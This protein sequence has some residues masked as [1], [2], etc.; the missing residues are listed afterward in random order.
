MA[1]RLASS[2]DPKGLTALLNHGNDRAVAKA[3]AGQ[4]G[5]FLMQGLMQQADGGAMPVA[6]GVGGA[7]VSAMFASE[8][9]KLAMSGDKLG[10]ADFLLRSIDKQAGP[11]SG[12]NAASAADAK[13]P[14]AAS[15]PTPPAAAGPGLPLAPY[16]Q[17]N[18]V[19]PFG[20]GGGS[21]PNQQKSLPMP[22]A[23]ATPPPAAPAPTA[24][25]SGAILAPEQRG[26]QL[27]PGGAVPAS[28][29]TSSIH[30][31]ASPTEIASFT[32][33]LAPALQQAAE[34][35]GV[36]PRILLAQAALETGWGRSVVGN[37]V[38]GIKAGSSWSGAVVKAA[39]HE[40]QNGGTVTRTDS[41]RSYASLPEAVQDFASLIADSDRY[42][43]ALG[44]GDDAAAYASGLAAGG[45]ATDRAYAAKLAAVA[46]SPMLATAMASA[47]AVPPA[48]AKG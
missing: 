42:R 6:G 29:S 46:A 40:A 24:Q 23:P 15:T 17:L 16:W 37:N 10:L 21:A 30:G 5:A 31:A 4:F 28:S 19:R 22:S 47:A 8:M 1:E 35:L 34:Q 38:F 20:T 9:G 3:V 25:P 43:Q 27:G 12:P 2:A 18:G 39:T 48:A 13:A 26:A 36:S 41:F 11:A 7:T 32:A 44:A 45:Y 14:A 33:A